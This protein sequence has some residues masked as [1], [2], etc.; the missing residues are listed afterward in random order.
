MKKIVVGILAAA[1][2]GSTAITGMAGYAKCQT[3][4]C[5]SSYIDSN[6]DGICD[7]YFE[8]DCSG[9]GTG[10]VGK[11]VQTVV[12]SVENVAY[13]TAVQGSNYVDHDGDGICDNYS[14]GSCNGRGAGNC[15]AATAS[16]TVTETVVTA[17]VGQN[18]GQ[19]KNYV[20]SDRDGVCDNYESGNCNGGVCDGTGAGTHGN[21][22]GQSNGGG[23]HGGRNR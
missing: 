19:R 18:A 12:E 2:V 23:C 15:N 8:R 3:S 1:I 5:G 16:E 22:Y 14:G 21:R 6:G 4:D 13:K 17:G 20:D 7:N 9:S 10:K 11:A